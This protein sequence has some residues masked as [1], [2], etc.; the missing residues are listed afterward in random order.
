MRD[1]PFQLEIDSKLENLC[2]IA[3]FIATA[4]RQLSI[5][6]EMILKVQT[7]ADEACTNVIQHGYSGKGGII[8]ISCELQD[9]DF[10]ITIRDKGIS[11]D[12]NSVPPPD[13]E[14]DLDQRIIGG[15][16]IYLMKTLM[17]DISYS[18]D[19]EKG[20]ELIMK[21]RLTKMK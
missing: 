17:D 5:D 13:L 14:V 16:G 18:C 21:K 12:P 20:N 4:M 9:E 3:D 11:C 1:T 2:V 8:A 6:E 19:P 7:A 15:L 10:V